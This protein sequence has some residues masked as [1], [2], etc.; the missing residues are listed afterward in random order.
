VTPHS[1]AIG[2]IRNDLS[3]NDNAVRSLTMA[4]WRHSY[5]IKRLGLRP[6]VIVLALSRLTPG[7]V[8]AQQT[9][10]ALSYE[11]RGLLRTEATV[12]ALRH[13]TLLDGTGSLP[14]HN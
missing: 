7:V 2:S 3:A 9:T 10:F 8:H 6:C 1:L 11:M 5:I 12:V 4:A 13:V 14:R